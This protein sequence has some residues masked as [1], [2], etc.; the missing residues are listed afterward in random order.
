MAVAGRVFLALRERERIALKALV[1]GADDAQLAAVEQLVAITWNRRLLPPKPA[2]RAVFRAAKTMAKEGGEHLRP[3]VSATLMFAVVLAAKQANDPQFVRLGASWIKNAAG[4]RT[5]VRPTT[6]PRHQL[7]RWLRARAYRELRLLIGREEARVVA[8][9]VSVDELADT[10]RLLPTITIAKKL[11]PVLTPG[12][13]AKLSSRE[14]QVLKLIG[15]G[16]S[17]GEI[18]KRLGVTPSTIRQYKHRAR[19]KG[20]RL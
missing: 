15:D 2:D 6:L 20:Q 1:G 7:V 17:S 19:K 11:I 3:F 10:R 8:S 18:A 12:H 16:R 4:R 9:A 13:R 5:K 14:R